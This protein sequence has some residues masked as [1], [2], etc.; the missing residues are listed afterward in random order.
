M[1]FTVIISSLYISKK[2]IIIKKTR[3]R[4]GSIISEIHIYPQLK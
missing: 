1:I 2:K 3:E 4:F